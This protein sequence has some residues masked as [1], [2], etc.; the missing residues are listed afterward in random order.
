MSAEKAAPVRILLADDHKLVREGLRSILENELGMAIVGQAENGRTTVE[1][2][3]LLR[4]DVVIMDISMP[5][6]N[7]IEATRQIV[8]E[9]AGVRVIALSMHSDKRYVSEMLAAGASGYLLKHSAL[10]ELERAIRTVLDNKIYVSPDIAGVVVQDYLQH[11]ASSDAVQ[12]AQLTARER[13]ILQLIAEGRSTKD[14]AA[15]LHVSIPTIDTHKQHIMEKLKLYS[16]AELT[17]YAIRKGLTSL[18]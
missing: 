9:V 10:D 3:R 15:T 16:V 1:Q 5:D 14:I 12:P 8:S 18:E 7:G 17:K 13:E 4:P 6:L 2:T 11:L